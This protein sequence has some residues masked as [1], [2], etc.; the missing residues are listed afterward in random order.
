MSG[1][2]KGVFSSDSSST[3]RITA[4]EQ[5]TYGANLRRFLKKARDWRSKKRFAQTPKIVMIGDSICGGSWAEDFKSWLCEA[6][7]IASEDFA[8]H[9]YGGYPI[10]WM[11]PYIEETLIY[12]NPD[13]IIFN[14]YDTIGA[15]E[16]YKFVIEDV[17]KIIRD[18]TTADIAIG[19]WSMT[20]TIATAYLA[21]NTTLI[22]DDQYEWFNW[23]R[24]IAGVY[25]C[26]LIDF[27]EAVKNALDSGY[28]VAD[29]G[30]SGPHLSDAGYTI[31]HLPE[32][33]KHFGLSSWQTALNIPYPLRNKE[34]WIYFSPA[35]KNDWLKNAEQLTISGAGW[36]TDQISISTA[37]VG[38][39]IEVEMKDIIGFEIQ[40]GDTA[41]ADLLLQLSGG[42]YAAPSTFTNNGKPLQYI[43]EVLPIT[44]RY[45]WD[46]F[47]FKRPY[48][49]G[50]LVA[51]ELAD[52]SLRSGRYTIEVLNGGTNSCEIF[53][54]ASVSMG[55]FTVGQ[56]GTFVASNLSF[57]QKWNGELNYRVTGI[58]ETGD[59]Y[60]FFICNNWCDTLLS[61]GNEFSRIE[62]PTFLN[63]IDANNYVSWD[64]DTGEIRIVQEVANNP[65]VNWNGLTIGND[66]RII[67][68]ELSRTGTLKIRTDYPVIQFDVDAEYQIEEFTATNSNLKLRSWGSAS[69]LDVAFTLSCQDIT[70]G[71]IEQEGTNKVVGLERGDYVLKITATAGGMDLFGIN[72]LH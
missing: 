18:R 23:Y 25:N 5:R 38:D 65:Y 55:T 58:L 70:A 10:V 68:N 43:T 37:G 8:I 57:P 60:E 4:I 48:K 2:F 56:A 35:V 20:D 7:K 36:S 26:E 52:G 24:D 45:S 33:K 22:D 32:I 1:I 11:L 47:R 39:Y 34:E 49:K 61:Q 50:T 63:V 54:P 9:W 28:S 3:Q 29:L 27:N 53:N 40:H 46:R 6:Y 59:L 42:G 30:I 14:E 51:N 15:S 12:P 21:D 67:Y 44:D 41:N 64:Q 16:E 66:Y 71:G 13:L 17:I 69:A 62:E 72:L 19:T 31:V